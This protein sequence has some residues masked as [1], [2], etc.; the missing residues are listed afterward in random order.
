MVDAHVVGAA[1]Q[2]RSVARGAQVQC[3]VDDVTVDA[4]SI[5][6]PSGGQVALGCLQAQLAFEYVA[7]YRLGP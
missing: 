5:T 2:L 4:I 3:T 1:K 6:H 7:V